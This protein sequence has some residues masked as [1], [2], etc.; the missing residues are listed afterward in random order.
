MREQIADYEAKLEDPEISRGRRAGLKNNIANASRQLKVNLKHGQDHAKKQLAMTQ[1]AIARL[2]K[3]AESEA[4]DL[5]REQANYEKQRNELIDNYAANSAEELIAWRV[6]G[7]KVYVE[8]G[9]ILLAQ[10]S[11][12]QFNWRYS[13]LGNVLE[14]IHD[15]EVTGPELDSLTPAIVARQENRGFRRKHL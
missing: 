5:K 9:G 11:G 15:V 10:A 13:D 7:D 8:D 2:E 4:E 6:E 14:V 12:E 3:A 1:R